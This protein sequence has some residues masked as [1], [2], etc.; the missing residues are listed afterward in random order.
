MITIEFFK[1]LMNIYRKVKAS[2][3]SKRMLG[4]IRK[5]KNFNTCPQMLLGS[6]RQHHAKTSDV[7]YISYIVN[8][9]SYRDILAPLMITIDI[10]SK[11]QSIHY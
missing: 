6:C 9:H 2:W 7:A 10:W 4:Y 8:I 5:S 3:C 11:Y 1:I